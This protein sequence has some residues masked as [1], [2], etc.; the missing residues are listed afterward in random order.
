VVLVL[1]S[2]RLASSVVRPAGRA[3]ALDMRIKKRETG[4]RFS[5]EDEDEPH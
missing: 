1:G 5:H 3:E 2:R 4:F